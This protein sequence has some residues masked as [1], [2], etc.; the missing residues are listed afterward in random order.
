MQKELYSYMSQLSNLK[1][2]TESLEMEHQ[3][4]L[5][6]LQEKLNASELL[7]GEKEKLVKNFV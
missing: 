2:H 7:V 3:K 6:S 5:K 1:I 4:E